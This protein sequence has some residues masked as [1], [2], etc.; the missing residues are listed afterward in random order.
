MGGASAGGSQPAGGAAPPQCAGVI[1]M[2][3]AASGGAAMV[4]ASAAHTAPARP[5]CSRSTSEVGGGAFEAVPLSEAAAA[6]AAAALAPGAAVGKYRLRLFTG[7]RLSGGLAQG[8]RVRVVIQGEAGVALTQQL[9]RPRG[10]FGRGAADA[11]LLAA[12]RLGRVACLRVFHEP[13]GPALGG[14]WSLETIEL[15]DLQKG[16]SERNGVSGGVSGA[17]WVAEWAA[18]S[19]D[20][21]RGSG[22]SPRVARAHTQSISTPCT[23]HTPCTIQA[24]VHAWS[25]S[26]TCVAGLLPI[27]SGSL[28]AWHAGDT[29]RFVNPNKEGWL[30]RGERNALTL[31]PEVGRPEHQVDLGVDTQHWSCLPCGCTP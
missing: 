27:F 13:D 25:I 26:C 15:E 5:G 18:S 2:Y 14:G 4:A 12:P 6:A 17:L 22:C 3:G 1:A 24:D 30:F 19:A 20:H 7:D 11:F 8:Q 28:C 16:G 29:Y 23:I 21:W 10:A 9:P 31:K